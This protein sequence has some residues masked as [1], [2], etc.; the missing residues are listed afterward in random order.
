MIP[1]L[2]YALTDWSVL[3]GPA[4]ITPSQLAAGRPAPAMMT[5]QAPPEVQLQKTETSRKFELGLALGEA[6][7]LQEGSRTLPQV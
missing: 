5:H 7:G 2:V 6:E 4:L 3:A 1:S